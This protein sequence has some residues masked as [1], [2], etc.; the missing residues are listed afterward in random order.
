[1]EFEDL[2]VKEKKVKIHRFVN[3][4]NGNQVWLYEVQGGTHALPD[5]SINAAEEIWKFFSMYIK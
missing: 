1:M 4:I 3:G 5:G 2:P